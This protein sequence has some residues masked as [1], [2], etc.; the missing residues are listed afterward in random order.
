MVRIDSS[1]HNIHRYNTTEKEPV[2]YYNLGNFGTAY[3]PLMFTTNY[4]IG[5]KHGFNSFYTYYVNKNNIKF[6][7]TKTPYTHLAFIFGAKEEIIGGAEFA[8]NIKKQHNIAFAFKRNNFKGQSEYNQSIH[9]NLNVNYWFRSKSKFYD[10]KTAFIYNQVKNQENGGWAI[11]SVFKDNLYQGRKSFVETNMSTALNNYNQRELFAVQQFRIGEKVLDSINDSTKQK[12]IIP[13]YIIEHSIIYNNERFLFKAEKIDS[14]FFADSFLSADSTHDL[15][16]TWNISNEVWFK[17]VAVDSINTLRYGVGINYS[18]IKYKNLSDKKYFNDVQLKAFV[19]D[20]FNSVPFYYSAEAKLD[21]APYF[22][23]DFNV[24]ANLHYDFKNQMTMYA[25]LNISHTSPTKKEEQYISNHF[26][27]SNDFKK[28]F[29]QTSTIGFVWKDQILNVALQNQFIKNYIYYDTVAYP[30]QYNQSLNVM[31]LFI[32]KD[33]DFKFLYWSNQ[34]W[35]QFINHKDIV[36]L[37]LFAMKES[38]Y[39]KGGWFSG[40]LNA[41]I[42][43]DIFYNSNFK[44]NAYQPALATF[45]QQDKEKF[46]YYPIVDA[47]FTL[48]VKQTNVFMRFEHISQGMFKQKGIYTAPNYGYI[49]RAFRVG[50]FWNFYD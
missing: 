21:I 45:Y 49:D 17:N 36:R 31:Q 26:I 1:R 14:A 40:K 35:I 3:Y 41:H 6:F 38:V 29:N 10:L 50:V 44:A 18:L 46:K 32:T 42:G 4:D 25:K 30:K 7:D 27:W 16:K 8:Q 43:F 5:F 47:F 23:G 24:D 20:K 28:I 37:P 12:K 34:F 15:T 9:H 33:F 48:N 2:P 39:Y 22:F 19:K 13:K 11:D